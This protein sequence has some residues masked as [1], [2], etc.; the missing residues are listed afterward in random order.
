MSTA[1]RHDLDASLRKP[2]PPPRSQRLD[3]DLIADAF[4]DDN[5]GHGRAHVGKLFM[6]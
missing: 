4:D 5:G 1:E 3:S 6:T 2:D